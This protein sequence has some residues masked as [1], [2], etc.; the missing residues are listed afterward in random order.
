MNPALLL[1]TFLL[2]ILPYA[3][4]IVFLIGSI[5]RYRRLPYSVSSY[6]TQFLEGSQQFWAVAPFHIGIIVVLVGHL[7]ALLVPRWILAWNSVPLRLYILEGASLVCG[8]LALVGIIAIVLRRRSARRVR[9]VTTAM[10]IAVYALLF[11]QVLAGV[12]IAVFNGW[13]TS[14]FAALAAPYLTSLA[15]FQPDIAMLEAAPFMV[16]LHIVGAFVLLGLTPFSRMMHVLV[17]PWHYLVRR[18]QVVRWYGIRRGVR[19]AAGTA[20]PRIARST[21]G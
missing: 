17:M 19:T 14:W 11:V 9:S 2:V 10:D 1:D 13:G 6:S 20:S 21:R 7:I 8:M 18:T 5:A 15:F 3:A 4:V 12:Y 16:K